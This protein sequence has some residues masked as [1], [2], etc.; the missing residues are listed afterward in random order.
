MED[1][2]E[3]VRKEVTCSIC[4]TIFKEPKILP[5]L[6]TFCAKCLQI[7]WQQADTESVGIIKNKIIYCPQCR[8]KVL[9]NSVEKLP[10]SFSISRLVDIVEMQDRLNKEAPPICQSCSSNTRAV[11]SCT[12][13][14]IFLCTPCLDV[15][16]TLKV[17]SSHQINSLDDIKSGKV[18]VPSILDHKQE[19]CSIHPDK[20]LEMYCMKDKCLICLGCAVVEHRDHKCDFIFRIAK[21]EKEKINFTLPKVREQ[22]KKVEEAAAKVKSMQDQLQERKQKDVHRV[23]EVFLEITLALNERK[24]QMLDEINKTTMEKVQVL[25]KQH[26]ELTDLIAQMNGYLELM[27]VKLKSERDQAIIAM[28]EQMVNRGDA[29]MKVARLTKMSPI[30]KVPPKIEFP[31]LHNIKILV[32]LL[33]ISFY[34]RLELFSMRGFGS[35]PKFKVTVKDLS[36]QPVL[37]CSSLLDVK[38]FLDENSGAKVQQPRVT[39]NGNGFYEFSAINCFKSPDY[40]F[41]RV[42]QQQKYGSVFVQMFGKD[43]QGSPLR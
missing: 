32:Q 2:W 37:N 31:H 35:G 24:Q 13:C 3:K 27:E 20:P 5:C 22:V 11:A 29:L 43:I 39:Y 36:G 21:E 33:G 28:K 38:I 34:T 6:H 1:G 25:N 42:E 16:K 18:T 19:M 23:N 9:L 7:L 41:G 26:K 10:S 15:H 8:E 17:T 4:L 12:P 14:G 30:E 40:M